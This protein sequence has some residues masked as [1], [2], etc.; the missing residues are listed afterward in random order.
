[1]KGTLGSDL[2]NQIASGE[3]QTKK[4][5]IA[6][7]VK[8]RVSQA[9]EELI[10]VGARVR[11]LK[12]GDSRIGWLR[13]LNYA[14]RKVLDRLV[15][16]ESERVL[17]T[18]KVCTTLSEAEIQELDIFELNSLLK[19][20]YRANLADFSLFPYISAFVTTQTSANLWASRTNQVFDRTSITMY[21][22]ATL[23]LLAVPEH[24]RLWASLATVRQESIQKLERSLNT[25]TL[26]R[27]QVGKG[28]DKYVNELIRTLNGFQAD[29][30][31]PWVESVDFL[32]AQVEQPQ[33]DDGFGHSH[34][35][36]SVSGLMRELH[37]ML[38]GDKHETLMDTFYRRQIEMAEAKEAKVQEIIQ[39]RRA[40]MESLEDDGSLVVVTDAEVR[41]RERE[42]K[43][44]SSAF[45]RQMEAE[46]AGQDSEPTETGNERIAKYFGKHG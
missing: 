25:A 45:H 12:L 33:L 27:A 11:P 42:I 34:Q 38:H 17:L 26:I 1:M 8:D 23:P 29:L 18:L 24:L 37:G 30:L 9:M 21:D 39:Q 22:G 36:N 43:A 41:R 40:A 7:K 15:S 13:P 44:K 19:S 2:M 16:D 20:V 10:T 28:A 6:Q 31:D 32:K 14:E 46:L 5:E 3:L 4:P 35:D